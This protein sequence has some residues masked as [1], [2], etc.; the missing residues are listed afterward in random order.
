LCEEKSG[1]EC[2]CLGA[3]EGADDTGQLL[4]P[5][6]CDARD[7]KTYMYISKKASST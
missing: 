1:G 4:V 5:L 6:L 7:C 3:S 2:V